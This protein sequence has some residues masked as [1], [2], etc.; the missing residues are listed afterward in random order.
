MGNF[1]GDALA[2]LGKFTIEKITG[3]D[4]LNEEI[5]RSLPAQQDVVLQQLG[6][7]VDLVN[8]AHKQLQDTFDELSGHGV[9]FYSD[10]NLDGALKAVHQQYKAFRQNVEYVIDR[11]SRGQN[12]QFLLLYMEE[13]V[14]PLMRAYIHGCQK[15]LSNLAAPSL[16]GGTW[17]EVLRIIDFTNEVKREVN[18][19]VESIIQQIWNITD[20]LE[21]LVDELIN[22]WSPEGE[23]D[24]SDWRNRYNTQFQLLLTQ[25]KALTASLSQPVTASNPENGL[26]TLDQIKKLGEL[27]DLGLITVDEFESKKNKLL[28]QI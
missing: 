10:F 9:K 26:A 3:I 21:D 27:R 24:F 13:N 11:N 15:L 5:R 4:V 7:S 16:L 20:Q 8:E 22:S 25:Y 12:A 17:T 28:G 14:V 1:F 19:G 2:G 18:P 23:E 6:Q